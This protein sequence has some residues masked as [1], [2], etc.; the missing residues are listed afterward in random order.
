LPRNA[1]T[2]A[3]VMSSTGEGF[4]WTTFKKFS[5]DPPLIT[6]PDHHMM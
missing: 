1:I 4:H 6:A 5:A 3:S 2:F